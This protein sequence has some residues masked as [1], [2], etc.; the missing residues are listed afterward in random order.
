MG[1]VE[2]GGNQ[3]P[4]E[5]AGGEGFKGGQCRR[6]GGGDGFV[7]AGEV[8]K[9]EDGEV[10]AGNAGAVELVRRVFVAGVVEVDRGEGSLGAVDLRLRGLQ[11]CLLD[12]K[13]VNDAVGAEKAGE[14]KGVVTVPAG[15]VDGGH[16]GR[17]NPGQR[18][19]GEVCGGKKAGCSHRSCIFRGTLPR[20]PRAAKSGW[21]ALKS[22][23]GAVR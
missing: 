12:V 6:C 14:K 20:Q 10:D 8:A 15:G 23:G 1:A 16:S 22:T 5:Q 17:G 13:G 18:R 3:P 7:A 4:W 21:S 19:M 11:C 9:I 2:D